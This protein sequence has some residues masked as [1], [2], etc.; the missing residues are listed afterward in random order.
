MNSSAYYFHIKTKRVTDFQICI[1]VPL[2]V[3]IKNVA[4][5]TEKFWCC[6][7]KGLRIAAGH[8]FTDIREST[9]RQGYIWAMLLVLL[10]DQTVL[11]NWFKY[12]I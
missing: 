1:S 8:I 5:F 2:I 11:F 10:F 6:T 3:I 9:Q 12:Y 7:T 4:V